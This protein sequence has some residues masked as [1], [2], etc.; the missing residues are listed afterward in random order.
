LHAWSLVGACRE[1]IKR[2]FK[3]PRV[4]MLVTYKEPNTQVEHGRV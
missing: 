2:C 4:Q 3:N 1:P